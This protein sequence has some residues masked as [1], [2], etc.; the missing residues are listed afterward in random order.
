MTAT[1]ESSTPLETGAIDPASV[2]VAWLL[3]SAFFYW[4]PAMKCLTDLFPNTTV[5]TSRWHGFA[6]GLEDSFRVDIV[7]ERKLVALKK[8]DKGY[9][10]TFTYLPLQIV[11]RLSKFKPDVVF[12]NAFGVWTLL[13]LLSKFVSELR[14]VIAYEGS[15]P[16]VDYRNSPL[17]LAL[18]RWMVQTA[19]ACIS[20][21]HAGRDYLINVLNSDPERTFVQ[22]YEV[23]GTESLKVDDS[24]VENELSDLP[25]PRFL[26]V[27]SLIPRKGLKPWLNACANLERREIGDYSI[28]IVGDGER[29][30]ELEA[31]CRD[32]GIE[33][34]VRWVGRVPYHQLGAYFQQSDIFVLPTFEDTWGM[35]VLEAMVLGKPVLCSEYAGAVELIR[36]GEN[37]Y[38]C[39]PNQL[40]MFADLM[41]KFVEN[42]EL[43]SQLGENARQTMAQY[44]PEAAADFM[45][46]VIERVFG[47]ESHD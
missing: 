22:P 47:G 7:G 10:S 18:R 13:A 16:S 39:N 5:Y 2:R 4:Q 1:N 28:I 33:H 19:D 17:R 32:N 40:E 23:P 20:N 21:S 31:F 24:D 26:Y 29:R 38:R 11:G 35:V 27:G 12:S 14:V 9:G 42:P 25:N 44:T 30:E 3:T 45:K 37:G 6:P 41:A 15:S 8:A 36:D 43:A 46:Q 34:R